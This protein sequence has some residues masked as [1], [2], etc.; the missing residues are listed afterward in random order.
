MNTTSL[1]NLWSY[2]QGLTLSVQNKVWLAN[3]LY[4]AAKTEK[5]AEKV[6]DF[7]IITEDDLKVSPRILKIVENIKPMPN[8]I[9]YDQL[10]LQYL[11]Q[12][13]L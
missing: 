2:L 13:Y 3:H 8:D 11:T 10:K 5:S 7:P 6:V 4:E 9:D 12:K 1:A